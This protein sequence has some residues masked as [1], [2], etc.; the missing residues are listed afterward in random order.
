MPNSPLTP[1]PPF[2]PNPKCNSRTRSIPW[3]FKKKGFY[4]R[5]YPPYRVQRYQCHHCRR[6]FSSQTFST[7][8]WLRYTDLLETLFHRLVGGSCLRQISREFGVT[9]STLQR[10]AERLGRHCLLFHE[11]LRPRSAPDEPLVLDGFRTF[12]HSQYWPFDLNLLIG[13]SHFVYG[14]GEAEL[15]RSGTMRPAQKKRRILLESRHGRP[16]PQATKKSVEEL[17]ARIVPEDCTATIRSDEHQAYPL[18]FGLL[19]DRRLHHEQTSSKES[20]T[21]RNPLFPVNLADLLLRHSS[22]NHKRETIAFSKRRQGA[23]YR[24]AIWVVWRNYVKS[25]SENKKNSPP[26]VV[27]GLIRKRLSIA[28]ILE[29]RLFP[30]QIELSSWVSRCYDGRISTRRIERN[31][32]YQPAFAE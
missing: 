25:R 16:Y 21:T 9:H 27:L 22:A 1:I 23:M 11:Q 12:E 18:A 30:S 32:F 7:T 19:H 15:R 10:Q 4:L 24:A 2:C 31:R 29:N 26:A 20:R 6:N 3:R 5:T 8:Y 14:I 13:A 17:V 28:K